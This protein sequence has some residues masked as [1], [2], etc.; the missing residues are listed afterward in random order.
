VHIAAFTAERPHFDDS[1]AKPVPLD[2]SVS[3]LLLSYSEHSARVEA[4]PRPPWNA[5]KVTPSSCHDIC[6]P[7]ATV[8]YEP[9]IIMATMVILT[10]YDI[11]WNLE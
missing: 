11:K 5:A 9:V 8:R 4:S 2:H 7:Y 6:L 10:S 1:P 3:A